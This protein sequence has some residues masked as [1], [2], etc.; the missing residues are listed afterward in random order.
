MLRSRLVRPTIVS[1]LLVAAVTASSASAATT[2]KD[3]ERRALAALDVRAGNDPVV[4][5]RQPGTV[6]AG[7]AIRQAGVRD[8]ARAR[9]ATGAGVALRRAGVTTVEAPLVLRTGDEPSWLFYEDRAPY[10]AFQHAG[11]VALVGA[12]SGRVRVS[13]TLHWPP[14]IA[15]RLPAFLTDYD[16]YRADRH[17]VFVRAWRLADDAAGNRAEAIP[18]GGLFDRTSVFPGVAEVAADPAQ[19]ALARATT[20]GASSAHQRAADRLAAERSCVIRI[21]DTLGDF[22]DAGPVDR[23][24]AELGSAFVRLA[25]QNAGFFTARYRYRDGHTPAAFVQRTIAREGCRD[26]L[27]YVAGGGYPHGTPAVNVGT[28]AHSGGRLDQQ[29]VTATDLRAMARASR[30]VTFKVV[31][32]APYSG[33]FLSTVRRER[34]VT[35][36]LT[37]SGAREGS[38][39]DLGSVVDAAGRSVENR[40]NARRYLEFSNRLLEGMQCFLSRPAEVDRT[41]ALQD[42]GRVPSFLAW[43]VD[44]GSSLCAAGSLADRVVGGPHPTIFRRGPAPTAPPQVPAPATV[45]APTPAPAPAPP[46]TPGVPGAPGVSGPVAPTN[47]P[48]TA[49]SD[50]VTTPED[51]PVELTLAGTDPDG[52]PLTE[53]IVDP[54]EHGTLSGTGATRSYAPDP[55]FHGADRLTFVVSDG[56]ETSAP[57]TVEIAVTAVDD[58]PTVGGIGT[59]TF[60]EAQAPV[61]IAPDAVL[62][63]VDDA[64]LEGATVR[65]TDGFAPAEDR[66]AFADHAGIVGTYDASTGT[67]TLT[68][69]ASVADYRTALRGVTY[70][71][72][73]GDDPSTAPRTFTIT[74]D[75]GD[76]SSDPATGTITVEPANDAPVLG[77]GGNAVVFPEDDVDGVVINPAITVADADSATLRGASVRIASGLTSAEDRLLF[78]DQ[79]GIS[80]S[81][82]VDTGTLTLT[83]TASTAAYETALRSVRYRNLETGQPSTTPR[84]VEFTVDDG[85][86]T[87]NVSVAI[88]ST[89]DVDPTDDAPTVTTSAGSV[90]FTEAG[91]AV[92]LDP[93]LTVDDPDDATLLA[94][95]VRITGDVDVDVD[96]LLFDAQSGITGTYDTASGTLTLAGEASLADYQAALRTVRYVDLDVDDPEPTT[97]E[98]RFSVGNALNG[99]HA[100]RDLVVLPVNDAPVVTT[101]TG[102]VSFV[103]DDGAVVVD[104]G[105]IVADVDDATL[106]G[107][108]VQ[109]GTALLPQPGTLGFADTS[110]I[111]GLWNP[112][113]GTLTLIGT[114][115]VADYQAALRSITFDDPS[116]TP[117]AAD[118]TVRFTVRDAADVESTP[119]ARTL[120]VTPTDDR[121]TLTAGEGSPAFEEGDPPVAVDPGLA[122]ADPDS[123]TL[124]AAT[125]AITAGFTGSED[126]LVYT[127]VHGIAGGYDASTGVLTL[128][129]DATVAQYRAALR[130]VAYRNGSSAP[131]TTDRTIS[132]AV[133]DGNS[134]SLAA[135]TTVRIFAVNT[136]PT[137][138]SGG[139]VVRYAEGDPAVAIDDGITVADPD[140]AVLVGA[141]VAIVAGRVAGEDR[142]TFADQNGITGSYDAGTGVLTLNG[143]AT[144]ADYRTALRSVGYHNLDEADPTTTDRTVT[145]VVDDGDAQSGPVTSTVEVE[146]VPDAPALRTDAD[147]G[148]TFVEGGTAAEIDPLLVVSDPD[149]SE[150]SGATV[151]IRGGFSSAQGDAL[152]FADQSGIT[153]AYDAESGTLTLTGTATVAA[154]QA[155]LRT[156]TFGNASQ[157][158]TTARTIGFVVR[159]ESGAASD[160]ATQSLTVQRVDDPPA[161]DSGGALTYTENDPATAISPALMATDPDDP[162]SAG[163]TVTIGDGRA[164][165]EDRLRFTDQN[166][167]SGSYDA[168]SGVLTLSGTA[169]LADY[170][171]ALRSVAYENLSEDPS[172]ATRTVTYELRDADALAATTTATVVVVPANDAPVVPDG[173]LTGPTGAIGNTVLVGNDATDPAP[174]PAGPQKTVPL[175]L[176]ADAGDAEG[177]TLSVVPGTFTTDDGGRVTLEADGD[178]V[179]APR[180]GTSCTD[181]TDG[182][183]YTV[184]DDDATDPQTG[185]GHVTVEITDCVWYV[186][187][188]AVAGGD[189]G[190]G[191]PFDTLA[192]ADAAAITTGATVYVYRGD[193]TSSGLSGGITLDAGQRLVGAART[194]TAGGTTLETG[195]DAQRPSISGAVQ[196]G[197]GNVVEGLTIDGGG[198]RAIDG[199]AGD[200]GGTLRDLRLRADD[201]SGRAVSLVSTGGEWQVSDLTVTTTRGA[202]GIRLSNAGTVRFADAG[203]ITVDAAGPALTASSTA[204]A[205]TVDRTT[206]TAPAATGI[207]LTSTTGSLTLDD[208]SLTTSGTALALT[209]APVAVRRTATGARGT[210]SAGGAAVD[211]DD[212][213]GAPAVPAQ[214][215]LAQVSSTGGA[216]GIRL[217]GLG[218]G[219]F[220]ATGGTLSK[221]SSAAFTVEG[222]SGDVSYGGAIDDGAGLSAR[223]TDRSGGAVTLS[224]TISDSVDSGGGV[225]VRGG[226]GGSTAFSGSSKVLNTGAETAV[227][228]ALGG[229]HSVTFP[230]GGLVLTTTAGH[231]FSATGNGTVAV[232]G[233]GN[234]ITT[235]TGRALQIDGPD[236]LEAGATFRSIASN[237]APSGIRLNATG[238]D[239]GLTVTGTGT[240]GSG[241]TIAGSTGA[242]VDLAGTGAVSLTD[243]N[244]TN[245]QDDGI[246][247]VGVGGLTLTRPTVTGNGNAAGERGLDLS[248]L[249][250]TATLTNATVTG[251]ADDNVAIANDAATLSL[252]V[253]GGSFGLNH[254]SPVGGDGIRIRNAGTGGT[255]AT[256]RG[257]RFDRNRGDHVQV[258]T[259]AANS[260]AQNVLIEENTMIGDGNDPDA[261]T[262]GGGITVNPAGAA[263][264]TVVIKGNDITRA[265]DSAIVVNSPSDS[266][267]A[268]GA[269]IEANVIGRV[270]E[271]DSGSAT[272]DGIYVNGHGGSTITTRIAANRVFQWSNPYGIEIV[273]NDGDG[274]V[275]ATVQGNELRAP[276]AFALSPIRVLIGSFATDAGMSCVDVGHGTDVL[277]RN[278]LAGV[279]V[280]GEPDIRLRMAG[281]PSSRL[282]LPG[283]IGAP[284]DVAAVKSYLTARN[285]TDAAPTAGATLLAGTGGV[286]GLETPCPLP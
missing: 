198:A 135:T 136:P 226:T 82:D 159:D 40:Y 25:R 86:A 280:G 33:G 23:T 234:L 31:I 113:A 203:T 165:A 218:S 196:L 52:D 133:S 175:S 109:L 127:T 76:L 270:D 185:T 17:R 126:E 178:F 92:I 15:G 56:Q 119:A 173:A 138:G 2:A 12:R 231:G 130:S 65:L 189:G 237:G 264:T 216:Y 177:D 261:R 259:D 63:D 134:T 46:S 154:Y 169:T 48:P 277:L 71:N 143:T 199:A 236:L 224:G 35:L 115:S 241:G 228:M 206:V 174:D 24:R 38:F 121:P 97:R 55:D 51:T 101:S 181:P 183:D 123:A 166:G 87:S 10:Q 283:Y 157:D 110:E 278:T 57:A 11:R 148:A 117:D 248:E 140:D 182:F 42:A 125:V 70:E 258:T 32:D 176:L 39:V 255:T 188:D 108:T 47:L 256:I 219:T 202:E 54:P 220:S 194:L 41:I 139:N 242:G 60:A 269:T 7:T 222:G 180:A 18:A 44:R 217:R 156:V 124:S 229:T 61:T 230:G 80:G 213:G 240:A 13:T 72:V 145:F 26:V 77:G 150:L 62:A 233:N 282:Q 141:T 43:M 266:S 275:N 122:V 250:G 3:A 246:R 120:T 249:S 197:S 100:S 193:G 179:Y 144:L 207:A 254:E 171:S 167:I 16:A 184:T 243:V 209:R 279:G 75:D 147:G 146:A 94:A 116:D 114:A 221:Q 262:V 21:S 129:G 29:L 190:S 20:P 152:G 223:V 268:V 251:S 95:T 59:V 66:L 103:E 195:T 30:D 227:D 286:G 111:R 27:L 215:A 276:G 212:S 274:A 162:T 142:L 158:P 284:L 257:A 164:P 263:Q 163:A 90:S 68:G 8:A 187:N 6:P 271:A 168:D 45:P 4:V 58:A 225:A 155:A 98:V 89:V 153:G 211:V 214:I 28:R 69:S 50:A 235:T 137:L 67:L 149:S 106:S 160:E 200:A 64:A 79:A 81:Y 245:G 78:V 14:L 247:G 132:F 118:R 208:V 112:A 102:A 265:R 161:L 272:G 73:D 83:G 151:T 19:R 244:V 9:A 84:Q 238:V 96:R 131:T 186:R 170:R 172:A 232:T 85:A 128:T 74:V 260:A 49:I 205:G 210:I 34:N 191:A 201:V 22:Y 99:V 5:F 285:T 107:A 88:V 204:L 91:P 105:V 273:Q 36:L 37:S 239:G 53:A 93:G 281:G 1:T 253:S 267:A 252:T 104:P 192:E